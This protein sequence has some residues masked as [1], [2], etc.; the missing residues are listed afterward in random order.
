[1]YR[2]GDRNESRERK[3]AEKTAIPSKPSTGGSDCIDRLVQA[4][5]AA[6]TKHRRG[7]GNVLE[8]KQ[9]PDD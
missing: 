8:H 4:G 9:V 5:K 2:N 6:Y 3:N 1:M 7:G